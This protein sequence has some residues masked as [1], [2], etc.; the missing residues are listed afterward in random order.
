M[1]FDALYSMA[2]NV[3]YHYKKCFFITVVSAMMLTRQLH[4]KRNKPDI[5]EEDDYEGEIND[6]DFSFLDRFNSIITNETS[7]DIIE[8]WVT[9]DEDL[10]TFMIAT[11]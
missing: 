10:L 11:A 2:R 5:K 8:E 4:V 6:D 9:C 7:E 1:H 3:F